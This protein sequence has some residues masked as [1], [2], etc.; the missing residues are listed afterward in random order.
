M[1]GLVA[2]LIQ[3]TLVAAITTLAVRMIPVGAAAWRHVIWWLA[4]ALILAS[5]LA[6]YRTPNDIIGQAESAAYSVEAAPVTLPMPPAWLVVVAFGVWL[7]LAVT[8]LCR[9]LI[10]FQTLEQLLADSSPLDATRLARFPHWTAAA[11]PRPA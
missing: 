9:L 2:W 10:C 8:R 1:N 3:G 4:L 7:G 11:R 6:G 5:P